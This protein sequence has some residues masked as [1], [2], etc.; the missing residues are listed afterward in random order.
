MEKV[1]HIIHAKWIITGEPNQ[2][3]FENHAVIINGEIIKAILPS[4]QVSQHY[5]ST[6]TQTLASHVLTPGFINTHTHLSMNYFR[7][8]R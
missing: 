8:R 4:D 5:Q 6:D 1:D 7:G 2:D 3:P